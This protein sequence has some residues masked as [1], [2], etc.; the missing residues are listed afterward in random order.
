MDKTRIAYGISVFV[1]L[2]SGMT[3]YVLLRDLDNIVLFKYLKKPEILGMMRLELKSSMVA[4]ILKFNIPDLLWFMSGIFLIRFIWFNSK[5]EEKYYILIFI[6]IA[7]ILEISQVSNKVSGTFDILDLVFL[8]IGAFV[9]GLIYK[10][11]IKRR[12]V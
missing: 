6:L 7:F 9:E 1:F 4:D 3:I 2:I 10:Y 5:E 11:F 12:L 8:G